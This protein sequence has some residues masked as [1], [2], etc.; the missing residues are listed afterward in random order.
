MSNQTRYVAD[1]DTVETN[2]GLNLDE[3]SRAKLWA[4]MDM[5]NAKSTS[6]A[7][8]FNRA[9]EEGYNSAAEDFVLERVSFRSFPIERIC[10]RKNKRLIDSGLL[11]K[12]QAPEPY[13]F[14]DVTQLGFEMGYMRKLAEIA[15]L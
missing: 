9:F 2:S 12:G 13:D 3:Q 5:L 4:E 11:A 10:E 6:K 7:S 14:S 15:V 8:L 1:K